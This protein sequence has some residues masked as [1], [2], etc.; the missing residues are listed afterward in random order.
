MV[1]KNEFIRRE[2]HVAKQAAYALCSTAV[3]SRR[4]ES[5]STTI[6]IAFV[7]YLEREIL[8]QIRRLTLIQK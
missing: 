4:K 5:A 7:L 8:W 1:M 6:A 2:V 3:V